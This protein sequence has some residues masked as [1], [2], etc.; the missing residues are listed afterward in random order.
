[1]FAQAASH[2]SVYRHERELEGHGVMSKER[3]HPGMDLDMDL[4]NEGA[5]RP[6]CAAGGN[7][8]SNPE[9]TVLEASAVLRK[10]RSP[11]ALS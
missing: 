9:R 4:E 7:I 5:Q 11:D 1:M 2:V 6:M 10:N 8:S 3:F